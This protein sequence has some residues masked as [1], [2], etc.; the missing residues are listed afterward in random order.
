MDVKLDFFVAVLTG[1]AVIVPF[2][3]PWLEKRDK[4]KK[5]VYIIELIKTKDELEKIINTIKEGNKSP[6]LLEKLTENLKEIENDIN[7]SNKRFRINVF[8][9]FISVEIFFIFNYLSNIIIQKSWESG[10]HF[11]Q[12]ILKY[13]AMRILLILAIIVFAYVLATY[14]SKRFEIKNKFK[15]VTMYYV[16]MVV[17]FNII[18]LLTGVFSFYF[19]KHTDPFTKIY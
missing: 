8:L 14:V 9:V 6:I 4:L 17:L 3:I 2:I 7:S 10:L 15:N 5:T 13:P 11:L 1:L 12:G 16:S 18:L 19:L